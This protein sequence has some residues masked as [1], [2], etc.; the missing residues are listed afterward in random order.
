MSTQRH[1]SHEIQTEYINLQ[2]DFGF[3]HVFG[4]IKNKSALVRLLNALF[5]GKLVVK[6]VTYHDKEILPSA[7][8]GKWIRYDVYCT[9]PVMKADSPYYPGCLPTNCT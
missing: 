9:T 2:T 7:Q 4:S 1:K 6:D 8:K 3:K 5:K